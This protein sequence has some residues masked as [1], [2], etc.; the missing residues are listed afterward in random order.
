METWSPAF[1][2]SACLPS[3]HFF[4][5]SCHLWLPQRAVAARAG[6]HFLPQRGRGLRG[7]RGLSVRRTATTRLV[8]SLRPQYACRSN[9]REGRAQGRPCPALAAP[10]GHGRRLRVYF[11]SKH[12]PA[13][14]SRQRPQIPT[15][16]QITGSSPATQPLH[17][18]Y[19]YLATNWAL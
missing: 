8:V 6:L 15:R 7:D 2:E 13:A 4:Y 18:Y 5:R 9:G 14:L 3:N 16:I 17:A 19:F 10:H 1:G 11:S 12:D